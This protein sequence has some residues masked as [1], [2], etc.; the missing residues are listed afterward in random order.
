MFAGLSAL[1]RH[2]GVFLAISIAFGASLELK[3]WPQRWFRFLAMG[4]I[5]GAIWS[6]SLGLHYFE[7]R[8]FFP[9]VSAHQEHWFLADGLASYFKTLVLANPIQNF[10]IGSLIH[11]AFYGLL[12]FG[13]ARVL[14]KRLWAEGLYCLASLAIMPLQGELVDAF[15]FGAVLFP[16]LF[17]LGEFWQALPRWIAWPIFSIYLL[18]NLVVTWEYGIARWAY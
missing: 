9:A 17:A 3:T 11:H 5:S 12:L 7:G 10:R 14:Q 8:G 1:V 13:L 6:M 18:L 16:V 2:Q 4:M 15:R